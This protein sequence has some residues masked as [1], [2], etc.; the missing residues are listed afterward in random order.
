MANRNL[1][2]STFSKLAQPD[3]RN[4]AGGAAYRLSAEQA[5]A[6]YAVTGAFN[7]T[8]YATAET[9]LAQVKALAEAV[10]PDLLARTAVYARQRGSMKDMPALLCAVLSTRDVGLLDRAF[11][12]VMD[13]GKMV[14]SFV[15]MLRSGAVGRRSLGSGPKRMV[16]AWLDGQADEQ[17]FRQAVGTA[18]SL[19]DVIRMVHPKPQSAAR[20]ALY[21]YLLGKRTDEALLPPL[22]QAFEAYKARKKGAPPAVPFQMLT[23]LE[24]DAEAW[25]G[26]AAQASWQVTRQ[27]L[28]TFLRQGVFEDAA[29]TARIAA[30]LADAAEVRRARAFPYQLMMA[31]MAADE[32][33]PRAVRD[34]L[35]DAMEVA[36]ENV[37]RLPGRVAVC[38]DVSGSMQSPVTGHRKGA[39]SKVRC[40]DVAALVAAA[41]L[42]KNPQA[43]VLPFDTAV[44]RVDLNGRD[45]VMTNARRLALHGGGT[46]CASALRALNAAKAK[47]ELVVFVSDNESWVDKSVGRGTAT[48]R[49]W[50][51]LKRR[52]PG[53][54]LVNI[55]VQPYGT[56]QTPSGDDILNVGGFSDAVFDVVA[57]FASSRGGADH[58]VETIRNVKI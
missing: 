4:E 45:S 2:R 18:P 1:F 26:I 28:N 11:P 30:R 27:G 51:E 19:A 29:L 20:S 17:L 49:E 15:Q 41:V 47:V 50:A 24:L 52:S 33:V 44:R 34:A 13:N 35:Q 16:R 55:D 7:G 25:K 58:W 5:L 46:D 31:F 54:K 38:L 37:P 43:E 22:V 42:R 56:T 14:R 6:Q 32:R 21:G 10:S 9:Q 3:A 48:L 39:T 23:G 36:L 12:R 57:A 53:A 40:V 8:F